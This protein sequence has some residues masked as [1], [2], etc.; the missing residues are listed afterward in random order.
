[1]W[2][3]FFYNLCKILEKCKRRGWLDT[4]PIPSLSVVVEEGPG[5]NKPRRNAE[6]TW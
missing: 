3:V 6:K 2:G 5:K 1:V 4:L